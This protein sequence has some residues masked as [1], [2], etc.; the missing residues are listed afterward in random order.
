[1]S[2]RFR[3]LDHL[4]RYIVTS[5]ET[6]LGRKDHWIEVLTLLRENN[7]LLRVILSKEVHEAQT[8]ADIQRAL[9][10]LG[11]PEEKLQT[12]LAVVRSNI[13]KL[14]TAA[15]SLTPKGE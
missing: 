2:R 1:M 4:L 10:A 7:R 12:I 14:Q 3:W 6:L 15:Q 9:G 8:L 5:I 13:T 11:V